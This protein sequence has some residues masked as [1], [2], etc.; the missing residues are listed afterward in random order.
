MTT[1]YRS[2]AL[3]TF[4]TAWTTGRKPATPITGIQGRFIRMAPGQPDALTDDPDRRIVFLVNASTCTD[5]VGLTGYQV[6]MTIGWKPEYAREKVNQKYRFGFIAFPENLCRLGTWGN[7]LDEVIQLYPEIG[8]KLA[9]HR[10]ALSAMNPGSLKQMEQ[11]LGYRLIDVDKIGKSD[12]RFMT[13]DRYRNTTDTADHARA[14][15]YFTVHLKE[16]FY[17][18][19]WTRNDQGQRGCEEYIM[20]A[21]PISDLGEHYLAAL[22]VVIPRVQAAIRKLTAGELPMPPFYSADNAADWGYQPLVQARVPGQ[23]G[24]F[25]HATAWR[26]QHSITPANTDGRTV[27]LLIID[28]QN[29]FCNPLGSLYVA[30]RSG[31][32]AIDDCARTAQFIYGNLPRLT[33]IVPT[34]D[35]HLTHQIFFASFWIDGAGNPISP[36][37]TISTK[38]IDDGEVMPHPAMAALVGGNYAWLLKQVRFYC[39]EL[40]REGKYSL[41]VWPSHCVIGSQGHALNGVVYE[42]AMFH[43]FARYAQLEPEVKGANPFTEN[44]SVFRPEVLKRHDGQPLAQKNTKFIKTILGSDAVVI[45]GQ[46]A[47]HCVKSTI[48][49]LLAEVTAVDPALAKRVYILGDCTSSVVVPDVTDPVTRKVTQG[50]DFTPL[51]EAAFADFA[52][53]GMHVV[54]STVPMADWPGFRTH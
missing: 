11:R 44:Y 41:Y 10:V 48:A 12:P 53:A 33:R 31:N 4:A 5:L 43:A 22:D 18:D 27:T 26:K 3:A 21:R 36:H 40:E 7:V 38:Q 32:G 54:D 9:K 49:D 6:C 2:S 23:V 52:A 19:G 35:T 51:A 13:I 34:L 37:R 45:A 24:L 50:F 20:G 46:A 15:L 39:A 17:G 42:A 29:D 47:S 28:A 30:G 8:A 16:L 14:F 25:E 1:K